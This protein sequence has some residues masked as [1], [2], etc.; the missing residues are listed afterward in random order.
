MAIIKLLA[1][2]GLS[3]FLYCGSIWLTVR[4]DQRSFEPRQVSACVL[5]QARPAPEVRIGRF[6]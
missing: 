1:A 3:I 6:G 4:V 2:L 5:L